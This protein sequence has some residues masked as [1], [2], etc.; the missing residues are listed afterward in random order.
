MNSLSFFGISWAILVHQVPGRHCDARWQALMVAPSITWTCNFFGPGK[1]FF[2]QKMLLYHDNFGNLSGLN[3]EQPGSPSFWGLFKKYDQ[4][5][6]FR[7]WYFLGIPSQHG[8]QTMSPGVFKSGDVVHETL[9][10][11]QQNLQSGGYQHLVDSYRNYRNKHNSVSVSWIT[12]IRAK[13]ASNTTTVG[14]MK[15]DPTNHTFFFLRKQQRPPLQKNW[16]ILRHGLF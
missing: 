13:K 12:K 3:C 8:T 16:R 7:I 9:G 15:F 14:S 5:L 4:V 1:G 11:N 6:D 10:F 2:H